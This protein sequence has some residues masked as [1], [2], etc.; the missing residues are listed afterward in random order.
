MPRTQYLGNASARFI[1]EADKAEGRQQIRITRI[2]S[3]PIEE[4]AL[5]HARIT[6]VAKVATLIVPQDERYLSFGIVGVN[7]Q[8]DECLPHGIMCRAFAVPDTTSEL[9]W[10]GKISYESRIYCFE[11]TEKMLLPC[12]TVQ[13]SLLT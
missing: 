5:R 2:R 4:V 13:P 1:R 8:I 7:E 6:C 3:V 12:Y 11:C 10:Y 9:E